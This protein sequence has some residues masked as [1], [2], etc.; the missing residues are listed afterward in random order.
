MESS[1]KTNRLAIV[2]FASGLIAILSIGLIFVL[3]SSQED[4]RVSLLCRCA[5]CLGRPAT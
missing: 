2:S 1:I 5:R 4:R 3:Y